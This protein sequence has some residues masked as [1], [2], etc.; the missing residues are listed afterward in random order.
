MTG[1]VTG[2]VATKAPAVP[3]AD[4][5]EL[6]LYLRF[7]GLPYLRLTMAGG[8]FQS[9]EFFSP[10]PG[11]DLARRGRVTAADLKIDGDNLTGT[12]EVAEERDGGSTA[13]YRFTLGAIVEAERL[14]GYWRGTRDG[15]P[16]YTKSNKLYGTL[17]DGKAAATVAP[18]E[19]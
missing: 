10:E 4:A 9:G 12:L 17:R 11:K 5:K 6:E 16:I 18:G 8:K 1:R 7:S 13:R 14:A 2:E 19:P 15:E 3:L